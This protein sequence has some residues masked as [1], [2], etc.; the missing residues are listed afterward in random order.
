MGA[1]MTR[2]ELVTLVTR[3]APAYWCD[4]TNELVCAPCREQGLFQLGWLPL[5]EE[6]IN[7]LVLQDGSFAKCDRCGEEIS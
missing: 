6:Q 7:A 2:A 1:A 4:A 3:N 5:H